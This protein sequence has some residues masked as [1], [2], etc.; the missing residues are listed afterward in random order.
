MVWHEDWSWILGDGCLSCIWILI[1][2]IYLI[3]RLSFPPIKLPFIFVKFQLII[4][5]DLI[6][7][8]ILSYWSTCLSLHK[9]YDVLIILTLHYVLKSGSISSPTLFLSCKIVLTILGVRTHIICRIILSIATTT[10]KICW[11]F[12]WKCIEKK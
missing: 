8:C 2:P 11:D 10:T 5:V 3:K 12:D 7:D 1:T 9:H 6:L 4:C